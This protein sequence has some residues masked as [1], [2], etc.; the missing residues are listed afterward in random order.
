MKRKVY[1][2]YLLLEIFVAIALLAMCVA[3]FIEILP[4]TLKHEILTLQH[5]ELSRI[6]DVEFANILAD[7][8]SGK[9]S[10]DTLS[11]N[12]KTE[13]SNHEISLPKI[14][15][16]RPFTKTCQIRRTGK[17]I[18]NQQEES[19]LVLIKINFT[20]KTD[21]KFFAKFAPLIDSKNQKENR[22][23]YSYKVR[24]SKPA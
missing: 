14:L 1:H 19:C 4:K 13:L 15:A 22:L 6:S 18:R 5:L 10:W 2:S 23:T 16:K 8:H 20:P 11:S 24:V 3:P 17:L 21:P 9:I 7:L 12:K